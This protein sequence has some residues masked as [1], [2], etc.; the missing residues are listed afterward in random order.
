[1]SLIKQIALNLILF[2]GFFFG[3]VFTAN[4]LGLPTEKTDK[5]IVLYYIGLAY[6]AVSHV[7]KYS[8]SKYKK[9][10]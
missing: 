8:Y 7:I 9:K 2:S 1:M 3:L 10:Y 4:F 5:F 6:I